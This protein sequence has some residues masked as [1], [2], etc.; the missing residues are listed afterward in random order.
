MSLLN[1][2]E[3]MA[4]AFEKG[5]R[6]EKWHALFE[7]VDTFLYSPPSVT[8]TTAHVRDSLDLKRMMILVWACALPVLLF[9]MW[10]VGW[11]A[12]T[13]FAA[14]PELLAQQSGWHHALISMLSSHNP[15]SLWDCL[16][17]GAVWCSAAR[18]RTLSTPHS[19]AAP[20]C[21]LPTRPI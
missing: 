15:N 11:Q 21:S 16:V 8:K 12:N 19:Q 20:S 1:V 13:A 2:L 18:A 14:N 17:A 7:A 5:G 10:N 3:R 6:F 9:G 4:P